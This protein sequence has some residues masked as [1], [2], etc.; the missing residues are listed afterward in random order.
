MK[1]SLKWLE[2][3]FDKPL[4]RAEKVADAFTF[5]AFEVEEANG[6]LIDLKVLPNRAT[7]CLCHRGLA[8]E[9]S[10]VLDI[11]M[12]NDPLREELIDFPKT[13]ELEVKIEDP[14]K[15]G[16]YMGALVRGVK[17]GPSP[18]WLKESLEATGQRSINNVVDAANY[19]MLNI[20]QPLHAFDAEKLTKK[21]GKYVIEVRGAKKGEKMTTLSGDECALSEGMLLITD[22]KADKPIGIA[23]V[24]GGKV[25]EITETTTDI[26]I[27][28]ANFDGTNIRR[29]AQTLKLFTDASLRFQNRPSPELAAYGMKGVLALIQE[30][31][32]GEIV[33]VVDV[34]PLKPEIKSVRVTL[35][36]INGVLGASFSKAEVAGVFKRLDLLTEIQDEDFTITPPFERRDLIIPEDLVEEIG[37]ILGYD[38][39]PSIELPPISVAPDQA[40][41]RGTERMKDQLVL[42]GFI[43]VSTQSFAKKGDIILANPLDK[44]KPALRVNLED[45]LREALEIAKKYAPLTLSQN[46]KPKLFEVGTVFPKEGEY[47]ELRMTERVAEWGEKAGTSDNLSIAKLEEYGKDYTPERYTLGVYKPFSI[48]PFILRDIALFAEEGKEKE[49]LTI[50]KTEAGPLLFRADLFDVFTKDGKTSYAFH[51]VFQSQEK[52]LSD[53]E[54]NKIMDKVTRA[55]NNKKGWQVR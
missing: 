33:G 3:Y 28:S 12:K 32:G 8:K 29:T 35:A 6:D 11:P 46:E 34:Y 14:K 4:P 52:T 51:L 27:E 45:N 47:L 40:R 43:E 25:A 21:E 19:V 20:G 50:I 30:V 55:L 36:R 42:K 49:I 9:L 41:Y 48:Y 17:V 44:T 7:D 5:H 1:V 23:G 31:A 38:N 18:A 13:D 24:K 37:R 54:I 53:E 39:I 10:A 26:I 2:K 22:A 16:R 15:C